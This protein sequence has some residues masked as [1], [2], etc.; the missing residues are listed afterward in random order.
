ILVV[1]EPAA[2]CLGEGL[3]GE[4]ARL[5]RERERLHSARAVQAFAETGCGRL[6]DDEDSLFDQLGKLDREAQKWIALD[7]ALAETARRLDALA[8]EAQDLA[9]TLRNLAAGWPADPA[10]LEE[11]EDRLQLLRRL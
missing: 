4:L 5:L 2:A 3:D 10:R 8:A 1:M 6:Y 9:E 7:P 11:V